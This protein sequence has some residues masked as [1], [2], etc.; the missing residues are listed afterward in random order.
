MQKNLSEPF[1]SRKIKSFGGK[2]WR[3]KLHLAE[4]YF[5]MSTKEIRRFCHVSFGR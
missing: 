5:C 2:E 1:S 4:G 3:V